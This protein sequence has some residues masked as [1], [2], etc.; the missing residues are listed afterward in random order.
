MCGVSVEDLLSSMKLHDGPESRVE[1]LGAGD[2]LSIV[3]AEV[4]CSLAAAKSV[5]YSSWFDACSKYNRVVSFQPHEAPITPALPPKWHRH[6][7]QPL[8]SRC[9]VLP[10]A[11][12]A[13]LLQLLV[14][15]GASIQPEVFSP[16]KSSYPPGT[17][18]VVSSEIYKSGD[19]HSP[20]IIQLAS[21]GFPVVFATFFEDWALNAAPPPF[22]S[23]E[24]PEAKAAATKQSAAESTTASAPEVKG[25]SAPLSTDLAVSAV[26]RHTDKKNAKCSICRGASVLGSTGMHIVDIIDTSTSGHMACFQWLCSNAL[27]ALSVVQVSCFHLYLCIISAHLVTAGCSK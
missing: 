20:T 12:S 7:M 19:A 24:L 5:I 1:Q 2:D 23:Y 27:P 9:S 10:L 17:I 4:L 15:G 11:S 6:M 21:L 22:L 3:Q 18:V 25:D 8:F 16:S 14:A 13:H 26:F